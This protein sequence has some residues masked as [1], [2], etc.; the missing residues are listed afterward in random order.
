MGYSIVAPGTEARGEEEASPADVGD[1]GDSG[2][3]GV[4]GVNGSMMKDT[5][6]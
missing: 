2:V 3:P 5:L 1:P 6:W 4:P